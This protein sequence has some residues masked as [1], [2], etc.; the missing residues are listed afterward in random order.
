MV[1]LRILRDIF[2]VIYFWSYFA[3]LFMA[4]ETW[5]P[6]PKAPGRKVVC[7]REAEICSVKKIR[8]ARECG[9]VKP[10][11]STVAGRRLRSPV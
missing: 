4:S 10:E 11:G 1:L 6:A 8:R 9:P 7:K 5:F 3:Y 2:E